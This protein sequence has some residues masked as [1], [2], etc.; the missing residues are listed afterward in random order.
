MADQQ[1]KLG[2]EFLPFHPQ[3]SHIRPDYRDGWNDC[4]RAAMGG[5]HPHGGIAIRVV[6]SSSVPKDEIHVLDGAGRLV[7]R[8]IGVGHLGGAEGG[9][10]T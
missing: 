4:F 8:I 9:S 5:L 2:N 6:E 10:E 3:A 1:W 7:G